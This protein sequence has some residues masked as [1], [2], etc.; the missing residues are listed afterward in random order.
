M[1]ETVRSYILT[2]RER[3]ILKRFVESGEKLNGY[4]ILLH[5]LKKARDQLKDDLT[6]IEAAL[7]KT[8]AKFS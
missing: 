2:E 8:E 7:E 6:L 1:V 4:R 3:K 5:Y